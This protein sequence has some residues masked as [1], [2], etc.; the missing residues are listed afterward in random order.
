MMKKI[1]LTTL[2]FGLF[3]FSGHV[4]GQNWSFGLKAGADLSTLK[5]KVTEVLPSTIVS[6][7]T[8]KDYEYL[9]NFQ[10]GF[11]SKVQLNDQIGLTI[12]PGFIQKGAK[13]KN[14]GTNL[15]FGY[16]DVPLLLYYSPITKFNFEI[17]PELGYRIY[18][19]HDGN[20]VGLPF[21]KWDF[22]A[23]IGLSYDINEKINIG[24][25]Y[26]Y[27][28]SKMRDNIVFTEDGN[29][30]QSIIGNIDIDK[31]NRYFEVFVRYYLFKN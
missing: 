15:R 30:G 25:R 8:S 9:P 5:E 10:I 3:L 31:Y 24:S 4:F 11:I 21:S 2:V 18:Y 13:D 23:I 12:E 7:Y 26:S 1:K 29:G 28:L 16:F 14:L 6:P 27:G 17:G 20:Y 19:Q 22:S